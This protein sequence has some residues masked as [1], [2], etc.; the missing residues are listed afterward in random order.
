[1]AVSDR[2][3]N[4][5]EERPDCFKKCTNK[6]CWKNQVRETGCRITKARVA[7]LDVLKQSSEHYSADEIFQMVAKSYPGIGLATVYRTLD[8]LCEIG[9]ISSETFTEDCKRYEWIGSKNTNI[10]VHLVCKKCNRISHH[11]LK[12]DLEMTSYLLLLDKIHTENDYQIDK[13]NILIDGVCKECKKNK[14]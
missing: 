14:N 1:M 11:N 8:K 9:L 10:Q 12:S 13:V 4:C 5:L 2:K 3:V 7:I 6:E